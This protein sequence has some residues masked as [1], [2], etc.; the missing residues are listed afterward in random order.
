M[1]MGNMFTGLN[2]F[3]NNPAPTLENPTGTNF[4]WEYVWHCHILGHEENDMMRPIMFQVPPPAPSN[5]LA[6]S[7]TVNGGVKLTWTDNSASETGFTVQRDIDPAFPNPFLISVGPS[8][9]LNAVG[10]GTDWGATV[11]T[12]DTSSLVSGTT[13]YYRVQA[14]DDGF[15]SPFEQSYN[16]TSAVLS[17]WSNLAT[18]QPVP[19]AGISATLLAFGN[20]TVGTFTQTLA[21]GQLA[22]VTI[23][24]TG[25]ANLTLSS[26][27]TGS[28]DFTSTANGCV[29]VSAGATCQFSVTYTPTTVGAASAT[30]TFT[31]NDPA[32]PTLVVS[33]T[34]AGIVN[35]A[36]ALSSPPV[37]YNADGIV[38]I[39]VTSTPAGFTPTGNV[40][41]TVDG[42]TPISQ[43]LAS[44]S[45]VFTLVA[46]NA[47]NHTLL[48]AYATQ[49]GFQGST[50]SGTLT[51]NQQPLAISPTPNPATMAYGGPLPSL[52]PS[53]NGFLT[54]QGP[55]NLTGTATCSTTAT[56]ASTVGAYTSVCA[57]ATSTNYA[58]SYPAGVVNVAKATS[59]TTITS[60]TPSPAIIG[61]IVTVSFRVA[62]QFSGIPTG[63]VTVT[64][65]TGESCTGA[66][67]AGVGSC[68][69]TFVTGGNRPLT[70]VYSGDGNFLTSTSTPATQVVSNIS[71]STFSL[72]FGNQLVGT[73]SS[74]QTVTLANVGTTTLTITGI[75]WSA[76]F[77]DSTNCG[78]SLAAGRSCRINVAFVPTTVGVITGKLTITDSDATSPQSVTL[79]GTGITAPAMTPNPASLTFP[80]TRVGV[81]SSPLPVTVTST[82]GSNLILSGITIGGG[83][84]GDF[85]QTNNCPIG[86]I[87]LAPGASCTVNVTFT[88]SRRNVRTSSLR[89]S[90]NAPNSPQSVP[91]SGTGQ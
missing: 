49:G 31:T 68:T 59:A 11:T 70:A 50:A 10:E 88:P 39:T 29:S 74:S 4:G 36:V 9:T 46:P 61:Q 62:P 89:V 87:G 12:T 65:G 21:N 20:V 3:S 83:N 73:R 23:S 67:T 1:G 55:G 51:V 34:G 32:H 37:T 64:A 56:S 66:L 8:A 91:L 26:V 38:T 42:G 60:N 43:A 52:T 30:I 72:L 40:T 90:D 25:N 44:G 86:G 69:L 15:K 82:G 81:T 13:Y 28:F 5:L 45:S 2:P 71:L 76:G 35:T 80:A 54:G 47:G 75:T 19:I 57:G 7:D 84:T 17:A 22:Q 41:L 77:S 16:N 48:A 63:S 27:Q 14:V 78:P 85:A 6:A 53:Y 79:T 33:V 18:I 58:I 24:N